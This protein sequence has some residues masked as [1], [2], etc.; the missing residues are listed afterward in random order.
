MKN[1]YTETDA[2]VLGESPRGGL[3][4]IVVH[5]VEI[6]LDTSAISLSLTVTHD[7]EGNTY[8]S[9]AEAEGDWTGEPLETVSE[10]ELRIGFQKMLKALVDEAVESAYRQHRSEADGGSDEQEPE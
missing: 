5:G 8:V 3:A 10:E 2:F 9:H 1:E 6:D 7:I 4:F